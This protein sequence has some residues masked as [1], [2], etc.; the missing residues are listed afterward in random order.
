MPS[1]GQSHNASLVMAHR[2]ASGRING[3]LKYYQLDTQD[4][5]RLLGKGKFLSK[6]LQWQRTLMSSLYCPFPNKP[7]M[8]S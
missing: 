7:T 4:L 2:Y 5:L 6:R 3:D 1:I 8:N